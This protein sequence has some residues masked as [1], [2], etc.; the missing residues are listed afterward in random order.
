MKRDLVTGHQPLATKRAAFTLIELLVVITVISILMAILIPSLHAARD[1]AKRT[2]CASNLQQIGRG[3]MAYGNDFDRLP[4]MGG[5]EMPWGLVTPDW[6]YMHLAYW[7]TDPDALGKERKR[8]RAYGLG[9]LHRNRVIENPKIFHCPADAKD[10]F[11]RYDYSAERYTWPFEKRDPMPSP[12]RGLYTSYYY[13]PQSAVRTK[14][15]SGYYA[16][17]FTKR[18]TS[19]NPHAPLALD[20]ITVNDH[21]RMNGHWRSGR[22]V[23]GM[24]ILYGDGSV[25]FRAWQDSEREFIR[26][27]TIDFIMNY[28]TYRTLLYM[29]RQ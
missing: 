22:K 9:A 16:Y 29:F 10:S 1:R 13:T 15:S 25:R 3:I 24:N 17:K 26:E 6:S 7:T 19:L 20:A 8:W 2:V 23:A 28:G 18:L 12:A 4:P 11:T 14:F 21:S 5:I 27:N